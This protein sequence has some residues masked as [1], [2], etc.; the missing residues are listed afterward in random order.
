MELGE[1]GRGDGGGAR[2]GVEA[3]RVG[4]ARRVRRGRRADR[5]RSH[6]GTAD[7]SGSG[8]PLTGGFST[9]GVRAGPLPVRGG[10]VVE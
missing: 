8:T 2:R 6:A 9:L 4:G 5:D 10:I 3:A 7:R 1:G